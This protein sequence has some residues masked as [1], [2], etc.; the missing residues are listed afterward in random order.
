MISVLIR[1]T[2]SIK[3]MGAGMVIVDIRKFL[4]GLIERFLCLEP[5]QIGAFIFQGIKVF[6]HWCI[7]IWISHSAHALCHMDEFAEF[8]KCPGC[9]LGTLVAVQYQSPMVFI[10]KSISR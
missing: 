3:A 6:L 10:Y 5:I 7:V 4:H 2:V 1:C 9:I 8:H